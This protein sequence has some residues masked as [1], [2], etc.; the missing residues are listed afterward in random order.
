[1]IAFP[2]STPLWIPSFVYLAAYAKERRAVPIS[3]RVLP[4]LL[5]I[6]LGGLALFALFSRNDPACWAVLPDGSAVSLD[7]APF[8]HDSRMTMGSGDLPPETRSS[9][10]VSDTITPLEALGALVLV[11]AAVAVIAVPRHVLAP[12]S[13]A[14]PADV[15]AESA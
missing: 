15:S 10:C 7:P 3:W 5:A 6:A 1:V 14:P 13:P 2:V 8:V 4:A 11:G 12:V 9:G